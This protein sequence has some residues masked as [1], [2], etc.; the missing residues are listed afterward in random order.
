[1]NSFGGLSFILV[2]GAQWLLC[3]YLLNERS[4]KV[5]SWDSSPGSEDSGMSLWE[6]PVADF[7]MFS[8]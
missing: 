1:M 6:G 2:A 3:K 7:D 8:F 4:E 5:A